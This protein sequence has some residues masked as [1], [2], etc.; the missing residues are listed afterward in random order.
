M[1]GPE[2][3]GME[4]VCI[5]VGKVCKGRKGNPCMCMYVGGGM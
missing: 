3:G 5:Y 2:G 1:G 4:D